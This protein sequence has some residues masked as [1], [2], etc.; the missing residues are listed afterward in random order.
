[1]KLSSEAIRKILDSH[2][3]WLSG[4][5]SGTKAD[6]TE[7]D[8]TEADLTGANLT[9]ANLTEADLI[10]AD[11]TG[12]NL[13][14]ANLTDADLTEADLRRANL[15]RANLTEANLTDADLTEANLTKANL[16]GANL[17]E[18]NLTGANII[19]Y[20]SGLWTAYIQPKHIRIG[21]QYH[22][23]EQWS[24]FDDEK[25]AAMHPF[26]LSYWRK[27]KAIILAIAESFKEEAA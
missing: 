17:T 20:H 8:L 11:L 19:S 6:L 12:A 22:T 2:A 9:G 7:A 26:A 1:M 5:C 15:T 10:G 24:S 23:V 18:A 25:I 21:C 13:T 4:D 16:T 27:N 14:R 3:K